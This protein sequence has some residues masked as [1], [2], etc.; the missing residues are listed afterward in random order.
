M[1]KTIS[2]GEYEAVLNAVRARPDRASIEMIQSVLGEG[3]ARRTLQR[4]LNELVK[5]GRLVAEGRKRGALYRLPAEGSVTVRPEAV[6]MTAEGGQVSAE[7]YVSMSAEGSRLRDL[8]SRPLT[9]RTPV[10]YRREFLLDYRP[11][12]TW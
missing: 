4:R 5:Q 12:E 9:Q 11:N 7:I 10:G 8:V 1:P 3:V 2:A 6:A